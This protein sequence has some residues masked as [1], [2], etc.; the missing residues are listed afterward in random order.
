[1]G[2]GRRGGLTMLIEVNL[3]IPTRHKMD[4]KKRVPKKIKHICICNNGKECPR[5]T[6]ELPFMLNHGVSEFTRGGLYMH[7]LT[8][9]SLSFDEDMFFFMH[10]RVCVCSIQVTS[11]DLCIPF[12][13]LLSLS[14]R[15]NYKL[16]GKGIT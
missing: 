2:G 6:S 8:F 16:Q 1:M 3:G 12:P 7:V 4:W 13:L 5:S 11:S 9:V 14:K 15:K 10:H